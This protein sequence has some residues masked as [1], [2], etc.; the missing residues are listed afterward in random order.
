[1]QLDVDVDA[2]YH[3]ESFSD[4]LNEEGDVAPPASKQQPVLA[5]LPRD[6]HRMNV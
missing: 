6:T 3:G 2:S 1:M 5:R 4:V